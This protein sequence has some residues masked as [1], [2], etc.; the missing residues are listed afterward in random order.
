[1]TSIK[2]FNSKCEYERKMA[3]IPILSVHYEAQDKEIFLKLIEEI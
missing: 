1:M 2:I 3:E